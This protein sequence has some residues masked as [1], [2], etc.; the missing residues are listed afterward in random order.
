MSRRTYKRL[1]TVLLG[2]AVISLINPVGAVNIPEP[3]EW[4]FAANNSSLTPAQE[5]FLR[6]YVAN[7]KPAWT[8]G[9]ID[10]IVKD[11]DKL[12]QLGKALFWDY[13]VGGDGNACASCHFESGADNRV[14]N[15]ISPGLKHTVAEPW[16]V[17]P[18]PNGNDDNPTANGNMGP[19]RFNPASPAAAT[20]RTFELLPGQ[21]AED[22]S[23]GGVLNPT[24]FPLTQWDNSFVNVVVPQFL[25]P[26]AVIEG[27][28]TLTPALNVATFIGQRPNPAKVSVVDDVISSQGTFQ[29]NFHRGISN[30]PLVGAPTGLV[31][32]CDRNNLSTDPNSIDAV[33]MGRGVKADGSAQPAG[34]FFR[35]V[36]PRN[37]PT[38]IGACRNNKNFWDGRAK[39]NF[40]GVNPH[41][42]ADREASI[43]WF[44]QQTNQVTKKQILITNNSCA[45][46]AVGPV[47]SEIEMSCTGATFPEVARKLLMNANG[48]E[49]PALKDQ[50][51]SPEDSVLG[52]YATIGGPGLIRTYR[53]MV[54][55][56]FQPEV[57]KGSGSNGFTTLENNFTLIFGLAVAAYEST[58]QPNE[59]PFDLTPRQ[60]RQDIND[61]VNVLRQTGYLSRE[62]PTNTQVPFFG[63]GFNLL[64]GCYVTQTVL[65]VNNQQQNLQGTC[66]LPLV[67][68][69]GVNGQFDQD[70]LP[71]VSIPAG[72]LLG[73]QT[74]SVPGKINNWSATATEGMDLF[75]GNYSKFNPPVAVN[76]AL[77][78]PVT[79][80]ATTQAAC[81]AAGGVWDPIE[82]VCNLN[83]AACANGGNVFVPGV[84]GAPDA[85]T[86]GQA[87]CVA[88]G[89]IWQPGNPGQCV[90]QHVV[91]YDPA[92]D[93][94]TKEIN[95]VPAK[96]AGCIACHLNTEFTSAGVSSINHPAPFPMPVNAVCPPLAPPIALMDVMPM[97]NAAF[98]QAPIITDPN[99]LPQP[100]NNPAFALYDLGYYDV[101]VT[102]ADYD[103]GAGAVDP[104]ANPLSFSEQVW[105]A[106]S[107][108]MNEGGNVPPNP[109]D[110]A[111]ELLLVDFRLGFS[112]PLLGCVDPIAGLQI[113]PNA[114]APLN[115]CAIDPTVV[116]TAMRGAFKTPS[117]RNAALTPP[118]FHNGDHLTL[119]SVVQHYD[120]GCMFWTPETNPNLHPACIPRFLGTSGEHAV[121]TF[122]REQLVDPRVANRSGP[123][124]GP[125]LSIMDGYERINGV[126][127]QNPLTTD[128]GLVSSG[129]RLA[130]DKV[131]T[132]PAIG[133]M[134]LAS[135]NRPPMPSM[136]ER[137]RKGLNAIG[138]VTMQIYSSVMPG[139]RSGVVGEETSA[140]GVI[141]N[142]GDVKAVA[143]SLS[144][145]G[146][147]GD[148]T[149][150]AT[151]KYQA[152]QQGTNNLVGVPNTPADV[153]AGGSRNFV[154]WIKP[155][156]KF[157]ATDIP[158]RMKCSNADGAPVFKGVN[159]FL[160]SATITP[161]PDIVAI[162]ATPSGDGVLRIPG[163]SGSNAF[164]TAGINVGAAGSIKASVDT[165][166][167]NLPLELTVCQSN[168]Q[169]GACLA[170]PA[171]TTPSVNVAAGATVTFAVFAKATGTVP[172]DPANK[173]IFLRFK[174][175]DNVVR[176]ATSV[177]V[178]T[179]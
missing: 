171:A 64:G 55:N 76:A 37:T 38:V 145:G 78:G 90:S 71:V 135:D 56:A 75:M 23:P 21:R 164:G 144:M 158:I 170:A 40:N 30:Q 163:A 169:T 69:T 27:V 24:V 12:V 150:P 112:D 98:P 33:Y 154:F 70:G 114:N 177:A 149:V 162:G 95:A 115:F 54:E 32:E 44:N 172:F 11:Q 66:K 140:Y 5:V 153:Q 77:V 142:T 62:K 124:D 45:S 93:T 106:L 20:S 7:N 17:N 107:L 73:F 175:P 122:L 138:E 110:P 127:R 105:D 68:R 29:G 123:F 85:C 111:A 118:Y 121:A 57:W 128:F 178:T 34:L 35:K 18:P 179:Q 91:V 13:N 28:G 117:L 130:M 87:N 19:W 39:P 86:F 108:Q 126:P 72:A 67:T 48:Q 173:R 152:T 25:L 157:D 9:T 26:P 102:P 129:V 160:M 161:G 125:S 81:Q 139:A 155:T 101:G 147:P 65:D 80:P 53:Q 46:Q 74:V 165:G 83:Q 176:G 15:Q 51:V 97:I 151:F 109:V 31:N 22:L 47:L 141:I 100:V 159:T 94:C 52:G 49:V 16:P 58:L 116:H 166:G 137:L 134:G 6:D 96:N 92:R 84:G 88:A 120:L 42:L 136:E 156:A 146:E 119:E 10:Q 174:T 50:F 36:E 89:F 4:D 63:A 99:N 14:Q 133:A 103:A 132:L 8:Q 3:P 79:L 60:E 59:T 148:P 113:G 43:S 41:G 104:F 143:C 167:V 61:P 1:R 168:P 2:S 131:T 82:G